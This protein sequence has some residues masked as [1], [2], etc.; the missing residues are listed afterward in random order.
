MSLLFPISAHKFHFPTHQVLLI[1]PHVTENRVLAI[2]LLVFWNDC[3][4][5][6]SVC[7]S[8]NT[9]NGGNNLLTFAIGFNESVYSI[10]LFSKLLPPLTLRRLMS[11]IY[12]APIL[13]VSRS[14]TTTQHSR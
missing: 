12:G 8:D 7:L 10:G 13:D 9:K 11:Y 3:S 5:G 14:H 1:L 4:A 6:L 2:I